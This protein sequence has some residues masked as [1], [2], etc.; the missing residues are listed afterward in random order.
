M[1]VGVVSQV[2]ESCREFINTHSF[3]LLLKCQ[4]SG[5]LYFWI[6]IKQNLFLNIVQPV[7][8]RFGVSIFSLR[9]GPAIL[10]LEWP[11]F[12]L[13]LGRTPNAK[14]ERFSSINFYLVPKLIFH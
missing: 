5:H 14:D 9:P 13:F 10:S 4:I 7:N 11:D 12:P 1:I 8:P 2:L 6:S 3:S